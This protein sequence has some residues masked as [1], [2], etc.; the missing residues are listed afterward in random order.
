MIP[1]PV[2][3]HGREAVVYALDDDRVLKVFRNEDA[4]DR[5]A[6]EFAIASMLHAHGLP[7][8][9]PLEV[10]SFDGRPALV[11]RRVRGR[12]LN[13]TLAAAP[14]KLPTVAAQLAQVQVEWHR[15]DAPDVLPALHSIIETRVRSNTAL[16]AGLVD[17]ALRQLS[18][19]PV[20][21][22]LCHGNLHLGNVLIDNGRSVLVD[23]SDASRGDPMAE[24]AHTLVRYRCARLRAGSPRVATVGSAA[25]RV[26][27]GPLYLGAYRRLAIVDDALVARWEGVRAVERL[28]ENHRHER[29]RLIRL[30][31]RRLSV[32]R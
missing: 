11:S 30:A 23:C 7:V 14:W 12:D 6:A 10:T 24:I 22:R 26:A 1:G 3:G 25:G 13:A 21:D 4:G 17:L 32:D 20:G 18:S 19:L 16:P 31:Y 5:A 9:L 15:L 28:A 8:A 2:L 29:R 27:I